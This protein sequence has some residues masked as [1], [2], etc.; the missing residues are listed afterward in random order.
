M[1]PDEAIASLDSR[2]RE[3]GQTVKLRQGSQ[4]RMLRAF[5]R[6]YQPSELGNGVQQ[7]DSLVVLSPSELARHGLVEIKRLDRLEV[8]ARARIV[9]YATPTLIGDTVVR[10][11][12]LIRG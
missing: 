12:V 6:G 9:E 10:W 2:I 7:G 1:T 5:V 4:E 3:S 11:D 8:G